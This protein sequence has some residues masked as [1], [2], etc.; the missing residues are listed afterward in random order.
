[1]ICLILIDIVF[2]FEFLFVFT[3][4]QM[5]CVEGYISEAS[6]GEANARRGLVWG[7]EKG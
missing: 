4:L 1:M 3:E 7:L 2:Q 6:S 5:D